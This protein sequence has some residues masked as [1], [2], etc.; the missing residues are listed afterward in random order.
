MS[1]FG[2]FQRNNR[3]S[4]TGPAVSA[5]AGA[6]CAI[7]TTFF[8]PPRHFLG[9]QIWS[10][11]DTVWLLQITYKGN[12]CQK[13]GKTQSSRAVLRCNSQGEEKGPRWAGKGQETE[14]SKSLSGHRRNHFL[15]GLFFQSL[16]STFVL[17]WQNYVKIYFC[18]SNE[19]PQYTPWKGKTGVL[20]SI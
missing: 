6:W 8:F 11:A 13:S 16:Q 5:G 20:V 2:P 9:R 12:L 19:Q 1:G 14:E 3:S 4:M 15:V 7:A 10:L 17:H 18:R